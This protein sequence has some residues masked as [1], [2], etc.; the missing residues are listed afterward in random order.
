MLV[1]RHE[2]VRLSKLAW[3]HE[4]DVVGVTFYRRCEL[5]A[6]KLVAVKLHFDSCGLR[7]AARQQAEDLYH[8]PT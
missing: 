2:Y 5:D 1:S 4:V 8:P 7:H 3:V 6:R